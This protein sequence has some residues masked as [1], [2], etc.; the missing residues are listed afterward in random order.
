M[1]IYPCK[2]PVSDISV[3]N[4]FLV[5]KCVKCGKFPKTGAAYYMCDLCFKRFCCNCVS[6]FTI[7][8]T[9]KPRK[10]RSKK[11][12]GEKKKTKE[13]KPDKIEKQEKTKTPSKEPKKVRHVVQTAAVRD[14]LCLRA[15]NVQNVPEMIAISQAVLSK[16]LNLSNINLIQDHYDLL[17]ESLKEFVGSKEYNQS[18]KLV[19]EY[20]SKQKK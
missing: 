4:Y 11:G 16:K 17:T 20:V 3:D 9:I 12:A 14:V 6:E 7:K 8:P 1:C 10:P 18:I 5:T 13:K 19:K 2:G 15:S